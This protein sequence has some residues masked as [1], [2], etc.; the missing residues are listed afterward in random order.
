MTYTL[1]NLRESGIPWYVLL[2]IQKLMKN[3]TSHFK[4]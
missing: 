2:S 3:C 4:R 1:D